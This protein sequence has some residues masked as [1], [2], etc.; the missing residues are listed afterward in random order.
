MLNECQNFWLVVF[1]LI[2]SDLCIDLISAG[3]LTRGTD[4]Q[5]IDA[6]DAAGEED[7][8][9]ADANKTAERGTTTEPDLPGES[10]T[11]KERLRDF[12]EAWTE[13]LWEII[14]THTNKTTHRVSEKDFQW[15]W[16]CPFIAVVQVLAQQERLERSEE[17]RMERELHKQLVAER[18]QAH[19][20]KH[21][22]I[23]RGILEQI[24]DLATKAGE[25]RLLTAK[26][27]FPWSLF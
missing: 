3:G 11:R 17:I 14:N 9:A 20:R 1:V 10:S 16:L 8:C 26:Y 2:T 23:C 22:D 19:Y 24:V 15:S 13:K 25:Y 7:H 18:A 5:S 4:G 6:S 12:Q 21:F 27:L